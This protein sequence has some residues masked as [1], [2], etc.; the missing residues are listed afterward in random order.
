MKRRVVHIDSLVVYGDA[1]PTWGSEALARSVEANLTRMLG[2]Q[3]SGPGAS[4]RSDVVQIRA[5]AGNDHSTGAIAQAVAHA[6]HMA[7]KGRT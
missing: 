2:A 6:V 5:Q 7:M 3:S 4:R 1:I